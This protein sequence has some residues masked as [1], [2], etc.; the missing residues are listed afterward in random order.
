MTLTLVEQVAVDLV[1]DDRQ[2]ALEADLGH[3]RELVSREDT[4]H[5]VVRIAEQE[6]A[7]AGVDGGAERVQIRGVAAVAIAGERDVVARQLVI[8]RRAEDRGIDRHLH[9]EPVARPGERAAGHVE[10]GDHARDHDDRLGRHRPAV[11]LLQTVHEDL[12][13]L[14]LLE[15]VAVHAVLDPLAQRADH[16]LRR[17][18]VHVRDPE[19]EHV[20]G[21][22]P[23]L[24]AGGGAALDDAVEVVGHVGHLR[25]GHPPHPALSPE[26]RGLSATLAP[27]GRGQGE[28]RIHG[29]GTRDRTRR[30]PR[31][32]DRRRCTSSPR[33]T[34]PCGAAS[35]WRWCRP[36][37]SR[38]CRRGGRSRSSRRSG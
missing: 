38:S 34:S 33:R 4:T 25:G 9:E 16:R 32:P 31:R 1:R 15:A 19:R 12:G 13:E 23:P 18:E 5:R 35:R 20:G 8:A 7:R 27:K 17:G 3:A 14:R 37:A 26:G 11:A 29:G 10:A 22:L 28:G 36:C 24:V 21:I 30:G 6:R 2:V